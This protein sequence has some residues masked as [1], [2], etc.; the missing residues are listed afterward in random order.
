[1]PGSEKQKRISDQR[2]YPR[3]PTAITAR[4]SIPAEAIIRDCVVTDLSAGGAGLEYSDAA[5]RAELICFLTIHG[6]GS[7]DGITTGDCEAARG[8][9][10]LIGEAE[11]GRLLENLI[12]Y[13]QD[14]MSNIGRDCN[15]ERGSQARLTFTRTNGE[16]HCC[17]VQAISLQGVALQTEVRPQLGELV[18]LGRLYGRVVR[19]DAEGVGIQFVSVVGEQEKAAP[20]QLALG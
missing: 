19:H 12:A 1:M 20:N 7:F 15:G 4:I 14:G 5:P 8:V 16:L 11:R 6:F 9:R 17:E 2:A 10:F 3:V 13:I 18:K